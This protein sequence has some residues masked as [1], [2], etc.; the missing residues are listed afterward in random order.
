[1][2]LDFLSLTFQLAVLLGMRKDKFD[3]AQRTEVKIFD[4]E[5][6]N[7]GTVLLIWLK[8]EGI[9]HIGDGVLVT[10]L[11]WLSSRSLS[12]GSQIRH[13]SLL[14]ASWESNRTELKSKSRKKWHVSDERG[15]G[16]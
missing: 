15:Q 11:G 6:E 5:E 12:L 16:Q 1:M 7:Q 13:Y 9:Q 3:T 2:T 14:F 10:C 4:V 8:N